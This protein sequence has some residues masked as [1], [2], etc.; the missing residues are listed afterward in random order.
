MKSLEDQLPPRRTTSSG[1]GAN[2]SGTELTPKEWSGIDVP[3]PRERSVLDF[4]LA[5]VESQPDAVAIKEGE[6]LMTY[7]E[8]D[9]RS[10]HLAN[11]LS[12]FGV[13][14][15]EPVVIL[16]PA[17]C[18][19]LTAVF[20]ILKAGGTY[21][22]IDVDVPV[23]RI[24]FL[25]SDSKSRLVLSNVAGLKKLAAWSGTVLDVAQIL[26][27]AHAESKATHAP[28]DANRRA[29]ITYTS[30]STGLPKGVEIEHHALTNLICY[31]HKRLKL[32]SRDRATL[33]AYVAFDASVADIWPILSAGGIAVIPPKGILLNPDGLI[34][35]LAKEEITLTFVPTGLAE[36][37][38]T[39]PWPAGMK[40]RYLITGGDRLRVRPPAN[41]PFE[42]ING[43]GPTENTVFSTWSVVTPDD[44]SGQAPPI[45][46]PLDNTTA[47]VL[48]EQLQPVAV[49]VVGELYLGGEQVARGYLGRKELTE[50]R[51]LPDP[52]AA[53][54]GARMYRT[55]DWVRWLPDG[56]LDFLGRKDGQI[57]IRGRR[58]ELGEVEAAIYE[59]D[60]VQQVCC[61]PWL[62]EGMPSGIIAHI[63]PEKSGAKIGDELRAYLK[64]QLLDF[65][66]PS[67]FVM[68]ESLPLTPQGKLDRAALTALQ[69]AKPG[70][71]Q[72][73]TG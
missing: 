71:A 37:L 13:K 24:E 34:A 60:A 39:R 36:I 42:V 48:D 63:V 53:K 10:N 27:S 55:G 26:S 32:T 73:V 66:V 9:A 35:W 33:L 54:P 4:F 20:G 38:F 30:G 8:L 23:K 29:Y 59:H 46:G 67:D 14:L 45:G 11:E 61:V 2:I 70:E 41:L 15:E 72:P 58:V 69:A 1:S 3:F 21:F 65:M 50:E 5:M 68:H 31:Y 16:L 51:F 56:E 52:F 44:G 62:D 19:F 6:R 49:G 12:R 47:Y 7:R 64:E 57:Q 18:D 25:L 17:S 28:S 43:Y 40:L 22:P